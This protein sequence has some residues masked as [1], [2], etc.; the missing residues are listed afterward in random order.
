MV[1]AFVSRTFFK[2]K[3]SQPVRNGSGSPRVLSTPSGRAPVTT[4]EHRWDGASDERGENG[5]R[6]RWG[7]GKPF[8]AAGRGPPGAPPAGPPRP[9][10]AAPRPAPPDPDPARPRRRARRV[11]ARSGPGGSRL[12]GPGPR[13]ARHLLPPP[14]AAPRPA[15]RKGVGCARDPGARPARAARTGCARRGAARGPRVAEAVPAAHACRS[16][17][18]KCNFCASDCEARDR[19][20]TRLGDFALHVG[21]PAFHGAERLGADGPEGSSQTRPTDVSSRA[22]VLFSFSYL[23]KLHKC[24]LRYLI[25]S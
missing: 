15:S 8:R 20:Q 4:S 1:F 18:L 5:R 2:R 14:A 6:R 23:L 12:P 3:N 17:A 10:A 22:F 21:Y 19:E 13:R 7:S 11:A 16:R 24:I 25:T 9:Q